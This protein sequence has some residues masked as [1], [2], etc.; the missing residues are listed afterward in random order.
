MPSKELLEELYTEEIYGIPEKV[1]VFV[2]KAWG[3]VLES[4]QVQLEKIL[5][6][7]KLSLSAIQIKT[8]STID[9]REMSR[10]RAS[11]VISFGCKWNPDL[12]LYKIHKLDETQIICC[13]PLNELSPTSKETLWKALQEMFLHKKV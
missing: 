5:K 8:Q 10:L 2:S 1:V 9:T 7:I 11:A 4:E 3:E 6:A 13:D 12:T